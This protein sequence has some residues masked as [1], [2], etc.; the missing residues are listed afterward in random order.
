MHND[1]PLLHSVVVGDKT[2]S[3]GEGVILRPGSSVEGEQNAVLEF[4]RKW[5]AIK[6]PEIE[7][8]KEAVNAQ[9]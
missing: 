3:P 8:I 4:G 7:A 1:I 9:R 6:T 2:G 5:F